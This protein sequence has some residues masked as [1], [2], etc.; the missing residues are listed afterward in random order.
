[1]EGVVAPCASA[2]MQ[3]K[4][5][6]KSRTLPRQRINAIIQKIDRHADFPVAQGVIYVEPKPNWDQFCLHVR[7]HEYQHV[8]DHKWLA[9]QIIGP[10]DAWQTYTRTERR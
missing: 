7:N 9:Q 5:F 2:Q 8:A 6:W 10:L 1:M 3:H 4:R